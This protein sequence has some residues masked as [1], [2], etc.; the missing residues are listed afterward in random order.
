MYCEDYR[1]RFVEGKSYNKETKK[2][3]I[4][5]KVNQNRFNNFWVI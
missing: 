2:E 1:A 4:L 5:N 3:S